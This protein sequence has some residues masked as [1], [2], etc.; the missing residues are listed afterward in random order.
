MKTLSSSRARWLVLPIVLGALLAES[1]ADIANLTTRGTIEAEAQVAIRPDESTFD[2]NPVRQ[3]DAPPDAFDVLSY[4]K[5]ARASAR[6]EGLTARG[7]AEGRGQVQMT[8][9][10]L[11][12]SASATTEATATRTHNALK[13]DNTGGGGSFSFSANF[14]VDS[15]SRFTLS[16]NGSVQTN[17]TFGSS[18]AQVLLQGTTDTG[19]DVK[20]DFD[21]ED[22]PGDPKT[23]TASK[24]GFLE[25][26]SY[27]I[28]V[29]TLSTIGPKQPT[30]RTS[31]TA[32]FSVSSP[33]PS[34]PPD[35]GEDIRWNDS[36]GGSYF[37]PENWIPQ[38]V[39]TQGQGR[40]DR[41]TFALDQS[42]NVDLT[43]N[44]A[45]CGTLLLTNGS[46][47]DMNNGTL[48]V[49]GDSTTD[50]SFV[51]TREAQLRISSSM[52][53]NTQNSRI[54]NDANRLGEVLVFGGQWNNAN[55][56]T[57]GHVGEGS[58]IISN[59]GRLM[60]ENTTVGGTS[61]G[62]GSIVVSGEGALFDSGFLSVGTSG[63]GRMEIRTGASANSS[64]A[65][66]GGLTN[67]GNGSVLVEGV[68]GFGPASTWLVTELLAVAGTSSIATLGINDGGIVDCNDLLLGS[69]GGGF[70]LSAVGG[71][72]ASGERSTLIGQTGTVGNLG[73]G[74]LI[75]FNGGLARF[76]GGPLVIGSGAEG[77]ISVEGSQQ[78]GGPTPE[79]QFND[80]TA[81]FSIG[82]GAGS[83]GHLQITGGGLVTVACPRMEIG[84]TD[85]GV[86]EVLVQG[87]GQGLFS[88]LNVTGALHVGG[89]TGGQAFLIVD[90]GRVTVTG[91][92]NIFVNGFVQGTGTV[93]ATGQ[94]NNDG[95]IAPGLLRRTLPAAPARL[96]LRGGEPL[97]D[98]R[99]GTLTIEGNLVL[100]PNGSVQA[101]IAGLG[102]GTGHDELVVTGDAN[103]TG[104]LVLQ[105]MNGFAPKNGDQFDVVKVTG[106]GSAFS[107]VQVAGLQPGAEFQVTTTAGVL[108]ATALNDAVA[109]PTV[110]VVAAGKKKAA[111]EKGRKPGVFLISRSGETSAPL[112]VNY[113][114]SGSAEN[115]IDYGFLEGAITIPA[116]KKAIAL[117]VKPIDD[118]SS[119]GPEPIH[120]NILPTADY[121]HSSQST[122]TL[123]LADNEPAPPT[124]P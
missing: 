90:G 32:S 49:T 1:R 72:R 21:A 5:T 54:G 68:S 102:A 118:K 112:T 53:L 85:F 31:V 33:A 6:K 3:T 22:D 69:T 16:G 70:G 38:Q 84:A 8:T 57:V 76:T 35:A 29:F 98:P 51:V 55:R 122:A 36:G 115:G 30:S 86:G 71:F 25:P 42:Y 110:S 73:T 74:I 45:S 104:K 97:A 67:D 93:S 101:E 20:F 103:L 79:L 47:V 59:G 61:R 11:S 108:K 44:S 99:I 18:E 4:S 87:Q 26:G 121:T 14:T 96:A 40:T 77:T 116:K 94:V 37:D 13:D 39:P 48:S 120:L 82:T 83:V 23:V 2:P 80:P 41:V 56:V 119:E 109:L 123:M 81:V 78:T 60:T 15:R 113:E 34:P 19:R 117:K 64:N 95:S 50:P 114:V 91:D 9:N 65:L 124:E 63:K 92:L 105:F 62:D 46:R 58:I 24:S 66:V 17:G 12:F 43:G 7:R 106:T 10:S 88:A 100:G 111:F 28:S 52:V 27:S 89:A 107:E 75:I